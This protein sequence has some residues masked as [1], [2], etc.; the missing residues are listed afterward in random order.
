MMVSSRPGTTVADP[1]IEAFL[2]AQWMARGLSVNTLAAYRR[3]L[4]A[5]AT[6]L[7]SRPLAS[8]SAADLFAFLGDRQAAG[9][10]VRSTARLLS[11]VR[12]Y[13]RFLLD[14]GVIAQDP[15]ARL[16]HP[17]LGR[18]LPRSLSEQQVDR[19]L[20]APAVATVIGLR[21]R[22]MLEVLY[23]TGLRVSEL[24]TLALTGVNVRQG[25]VRVVGKGGR[26]RLVP[27]GETALDWIARY[28]TEARPAL[29]RGRSSDVLFPSLRGGA[30][31]RQTFWHAIKR[32]ARLA[33][34]ETSISPH[35]LRHAFA[36]HLIDHGADLR[37]VQMMLGHA[38]LS[39][40]QIYTHVAQARLQ[41]LHRA[42]HP[43]G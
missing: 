30:M 18:R 15:S 39:T 34:I 31:T 17:R 7:D 19:L 42:H 41:A 26:E 9:Y 27:L 25:V 16:E 37:A 32:Y 6:W 10:H 13:Y 22:A 5:L 12:S 11:S 1:S 28:L 3:D 21:D 29:V 2:D 8:A 35:T 4:V 14:R 23:A 40:T 24:V 38:D 43:R 20:G 33:G 36:T